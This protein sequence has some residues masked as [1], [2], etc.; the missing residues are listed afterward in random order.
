MGEELGWRG[1]MLPK[2]LNQYSP[3]KS[4]IFLGVAWGVWHL[5]SF[6]FPGAAIPSFMEVTVGSILT[7]ICYTI[8][9]SFVFTYVFYKTGGS[10]FFAIL[11]HAFFNA[12]ANVASSFFPG[13]EDSGQQI[14]IYQV[15]IVLT[16]LLG[17]Y[18][19]ARLKKP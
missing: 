9:S 5:A 4:S 19:L 18:L 14:L 7:F 10:T 6:S 8:A 11:L 1:Y 2:L 3:V 13:M 12:S 16:A 15:S 17:F